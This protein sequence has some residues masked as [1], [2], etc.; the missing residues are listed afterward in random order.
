MIKLDPQFITTQQSTFDGSTSTT[1]TDTLFV[2]NVSLDFTTG[3]LYATIQ[4]GTVIQFDSNTSSFQ[5]NFPSLQLTVNPDGSFMSNDGAWSGSLG[6]AVAG[7]VA[8]LRAQFDQFILASG[9]VT[10]TAI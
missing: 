4:R 1:I 6:G 3:A 5:S 8:A 10:G 9:G 2:S 7:L